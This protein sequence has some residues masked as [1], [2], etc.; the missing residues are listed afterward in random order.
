MKKMLPLLFI[1]FSGYSCGGSSPDNSTVSVEESIVPEMGSEEWK[2]SEIES[3]KSDS[4][5]IRDTDYKDIAKGTNKEMTYAIDFLSSHS[6]TWRGYREAYR[7]FYTKDKRASI[8]IDYIVKNSKIKLNQVLPS[9]R[10]RFAENLA[11]SLWEQD[12]YVTT[13]GAQNTTLNITGG[14][15]AANKNI[16]DMQS[17]IQLDAKNFGFKQVRYRWYKGADEFTYYDL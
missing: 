14:I 13:S 16:S 10:K 12:I 9:Y 15:F 11:K 4:M 17:I 6:P 1:L 7:D 2:L 3:L 8:P 5:S